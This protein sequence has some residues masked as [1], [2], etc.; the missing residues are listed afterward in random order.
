MLVKQVLT[1]EK[2]NKN[3][4]CLARTGRH[5]FVLIIRSYWFSVVASSDDSTI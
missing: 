1:K 4:R 2:H 3:H 5:I